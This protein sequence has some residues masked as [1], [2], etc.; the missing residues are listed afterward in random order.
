[1]RYYDYEN[2]LIMWLQNYEIGRASWNIDEVPLET[3]WENLDEED[4]VADD[5]IIYAEE[6]NELEYLKDKNEELKNEIYF[7][8]EHI[9]MLNKYIDKLIEK[10][11]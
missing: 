1:M 11:E 4:E 10:K 2:A 9:K 7:L 6:E 8:E 3:F 5:Y